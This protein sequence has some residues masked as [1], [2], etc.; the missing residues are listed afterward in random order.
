[1][2][3]IDWNLRREGRCSSDPKL[4]SI[5]LARQGDSDASK[6][7]TVV[8][9]DASILSETVQPPQK[10]SEPQELVMPEG[11]STV[12]GWYGIFDIHYR[13]VAVCA[14]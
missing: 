12:N 9:R 10:D 11:K 3:T 8:G 6:K 7:S 13:S 14:P 5:F 4:M 1:M 2:K